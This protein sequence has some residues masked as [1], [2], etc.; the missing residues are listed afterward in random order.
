MQ[1]N[2]RGL[3]AS[4]S[5]WFESL[6]PASPSVHVGRWRVSGDDDVDAAVSAAAELAP[7]WSAT[8]PAARSGVLRRTATL[9]RESAEEITA[10]MVSE[11]G[12]PV[13]EAAAEVANA[14]GVLDFFSDRAML[15]AGGS[16]PGAATDDLLYTVR[17]P[18][19]VVA[20]I[21]PWNFPLNSPAIKIGAALAFGNTVVFKP[22]EQ[23][24]ASSLLLIAALRDAGLPDG[25]V[26]VLLGPGDI[27]GERLIQDSRLDGI[28]FTGSTDV[29]RRIRRAAADGHARV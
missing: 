14:A 7:V 6:N 10:T 3:F 18:I 8:P 13:A 26:S 27:V 29:G 21:T 9:L 2:D 20:V 11:V 17:A 25:V 16:L 4:G 19:G 15:T 28:S 12:K 1:D 24:T 23:A 22:A 5:T